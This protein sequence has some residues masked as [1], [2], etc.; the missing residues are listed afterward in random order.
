MV[1]VVYE[2]PESILRS[3]SCLRYI[4]SIFDFRYYLIYLFSAEIYLNNSGI[5][6]VSIIK[7]VPKIAE[8]TR[9]PTTTSL[10]L[11]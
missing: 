10:R 2:A 4:S 7:M 3:F 8:A 6:K 11:L 1:V 9:L 5:K